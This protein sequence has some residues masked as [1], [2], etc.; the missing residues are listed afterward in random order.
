MKWLF[1][2]GV[3][4]IAALGIWLVPQS[5]ND[6]EVWDGGG[7]AAGST[8]STPHH[9]LER[10]PSAVGTS[11][12]HGAAAET[13]APNVITE[14]ETITGTND[15]MGLIGRRVDLHVDVQNRA[16][17]QA[18]WVG[19]RDNR[20]LVVLDR[21]TR[22]G[23]QRQDGRAPNHRISPVHGGQRATISGVVR[24][25]PKAEHRY[26][27]NLTRED[28][29]ELKDRKIYIAADSVSSEGHGSH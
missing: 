24:P 11:G 12:T 6:R 16:N 19:S 20:L 13:D 28:E 4:V 3:I 15:G 23:A 10:S 27:W 22:D 8:S 5:R 9:D 25:V 17:D 21:D 14:I 29:R 26:S 7:V 2:L 1:A 18:F